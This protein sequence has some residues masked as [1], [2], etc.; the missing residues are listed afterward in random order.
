[1]GRE[2]LSAP[3]ILACPDASHKF[4]SDRLTHDVMARR[5]RE[6]W[7]ARAQP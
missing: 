4:V 6:G 3:V 2:A 7:P 5:C 1:M